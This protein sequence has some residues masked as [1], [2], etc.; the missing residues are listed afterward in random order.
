MQRKIIFGDYDSFETWGLTL[1]GYKLTDPEYKSNFVPV[2]GRDGDLDLSTA[3]TDG[4]PRFG[5]RTLTATFELSSGT[6]DTRLTTFNQIANV[7]S[8]RRMNIV[9]P[10]DTTHYID[11]RV[12][13]AVDYCDPYHGALTVKATCEPWRQALAEKSETLTAASTVKTATLTNA[14]R[15]LLVPTLVVSGSAA[16]VTVTFGSNTWTLAAGTYKLPDLL[17]RPGDNSLTYKGT[18]TIALT[19]REAIL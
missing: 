4:E 7:L 13:V 6:R 14:G 2:P 8:G 12:G 19:W 11:G 18:G 10:D 17:L 9:L 15:R 3:L 16:S 5:N 1:T